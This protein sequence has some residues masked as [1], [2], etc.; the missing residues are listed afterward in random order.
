MK[1]FIRLLTIIFLLL[2]VSIVTNGQTTIS[3]CVTDKRSGDPLVGVNIY[4]K[5][6]YDGTTTGPDGC[7]S[8]EIS[9]K[10]E[11]ILVFSFVGYENIES[12]LPE[13]NDIRLNMVMKEA[14]T[15]INAVTI[16]AGSFEAGDKKRA[17]VMDPMDIYTTAGSLGDIGA[18][19]KTL[20][21]TQIAPDDGRLLVRGGDASE[22]R[23]LMD[24]VLAAKPY[25]SKVP[26]LPT[27]GR[28]APS[29]FEGTFFS[30]GGYSAEFGQA[31]SS[32]LVLESMGVAKE[33]LTSISLMSIGGEL[34]QTSVGDNSSLSASAGYFN[35]GP[36]N[37]MVDNKI[38]WKKP[39]ESINANINYRKKDND[40]GLF[41][42]FAAGDY[43][44]QSLMVPDGIATDLIRID[45]KGGNIYAN[46]TYGKS[47]TENTVLKIG[48]SFT[49]DDQQMKAGVHQQ[50][51]KERVSE[52]KIKMIHQVDKSLKITWGGAWQMGHFDETYQNGESYFE[53]NTQFTDHL[54][55]GFVETEWQIVP[56]FALRPG[57][58]FEYSSQS[59]EQIWSPRGAIA[60][61]AGD[62]TT[63][64]LAWGHFHQTAQTDFLK[65]N[66]NIRMQKAEHF[67][68]GL[69][70]GDLS[71]RMFRAEAYHKEYDN[72]ITG[73]YNNYA[74]FEPVNN[75]GSGYARGFDLF[76]RDKILIKNTDFWI[77]Y[78][79][80]DSKRKFLDYPKKV[81][82]EFISPHTFNFVA[83]YFIVPVRTQIG[84][85]WMWNTGR[86]YHIPGET[87]FMDHTSPNYSDL[88]VNLSHLTSILGNFT[89]IHF[90]ISNVLGRDHVLGH[91]RV[92]IVG[93]NGQSS[94]VTIRPDVKQF[95]FLGVFISI[96]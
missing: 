60:I 53:W 17:A 61:G 4:L 30:T 28:F 54:T 87:D 35:F 14:I 66:R 32:V 46:S 50:D 27:R 62:N 91:R 45:D 25:Y 16:T 56:R 22:T 89:I 73:H 77:S 58:R 75:Q 40:G 90:S 13:K 48:G 44:D 24:G 78:S 69:Q 39:V 43:G 3:G 8:L 93:E 67:I 5:G 76:F 68:A 7:Y 33:N 47:L 52:G 12:E 2:M 31:L 49:Y 74:E 95:M 1:P 92:P 88:G 83:K 26:D 11:R 71:T 59:K 36:Y 57:L 84:A 96:N 21:G 79:Y 81:V 15:S 20:P 37:S 29:L 64:S 19:L 85:T 51:T 18:A 80:I 72:L 38:D 23:V 82:P 41:K 65:Y 55:S 86:P 9:Q 10:E 6:S 70:T 42:L 94:L 34:A 63:F